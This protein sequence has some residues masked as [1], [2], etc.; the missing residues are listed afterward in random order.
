MVMIPPHP[1]SGLDEVLQ[2]L[3]R[4]RR[5]SG[6]FKEFWPAYL[7]SLAKLA[8]ASRAALI[9][10]PADPTQLPRKVTEWTNGKP[11][12]RSAASFNENWS[13]LARECSQKGFVCLALEPPSRADSRP[14]ALGVKL[15]V[16][17]VKESCVAAFLLLER[18]EA[19]AQDACQRL[20]LAAD[21]PLS[22][23]CH[24]T[25]VRT[26]Q[27]IE[28][29]AS[30]L[31][32]M[33][34][35]NAE[36]RFLA[37]GLTLC[38]GLAARFQ[39]ER[40]SLGWFERGY[41]RLKAISRTE[42]FDKKMAA[43]KAIEMAMEECLDQDEEILWPV[44]E[45]HHVVARDHERLASEQRAGHVVS[46]PLRLG[47]QLVAALT[48]ERQNGPFSKS[49]ME[50]LRLACDQ[51]VRRLSD[52]QAA[53]RWFGA[54]WTSAWR[55]GLAKL[56]GPEHTWA[57]L[58]GLAG[59]GCM[60]AL[61][62]PWFSY[63]VEGNFILRSQEVS[64]LAAPFDGY[65][66]TVAVRPGDLLT[67]GAV[68][69]TL[70]TDQ[71][72]LEEAMGI[73][74]YTRFLREAEKARATHALAE[75]RIAQAQAEQAQARLDLVRYRLSRSIL[76]TPFAGA[77]IEGDQRERIGAPVSQGEV[78]FKIA[79][80]DDL[81]VEAEILE[82]DVHRV[83]A[84]STGEIAF[85]SQPKLKFPI[86]I[87]RVEPAAVPK[88]RQNVFLVR[89]KFS[90]PAQSWWR[91]GMSGVVKLEV[92]RCTLLWLLTHRTVDFL[93]IFLWW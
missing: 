19:Q 31:D 84:Q 16:D 25:A 85:V 61:L 89:C 62:V 45:G 81:Y 21:V 74:D 44:E 66:Q 48:A 58:G 38:N 6:T 4:L 3:A 7:S 79:R 86:R 33:A 92:G 72:E 64:I 67:N 37:A 53:D 13:S 56:L 65:I 90:D 28:K 12:N 82:R 46:L 55:T 93:R 54:R 68:L 47:D 69:L 17:E 5:F 59:A 27:D 50:Q 51:A 15:E 26:K 24:Q 1:E 14:F 76:K 29:F 60:A 77:V 49:E 9:L 80:L 2:E 91:P 11:A 43:V 18:S 87:E 40:V 41:V 22:Y 75:M 30:V 23:Q 63:R 39:C 88:D 78:L 42:R 70:N 36:T 52:L 57:K 32:L 8:R 73:A 83:L 34:L 10:V 35:V 71:L 20:T